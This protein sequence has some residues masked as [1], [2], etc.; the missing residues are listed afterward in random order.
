MNSGGHI[1]EKFQKF[2]A[3]VNRE[4]VKLTQVTDKIQQRLVGGIDTS[5]PGLVN[6]VREMQLELDHLKLKTKELQV[7]LE[8]LKISIYDLLDIKEQLPVLWKKIK[9]Y[10]QYRWAI[11]G[12]AAVIG[13]LIN[14]LWVYLL[15]FNA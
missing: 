14:K 9:I 15:K 7:E 11:L 8:K 13:Y 5:D 1:E 2:E 6:H 4:L 12:G 3:D 10:D